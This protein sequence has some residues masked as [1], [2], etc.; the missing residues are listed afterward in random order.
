LRLEVGK[1]CSRVTY[2][3][4]ST[5]RY[6]YAF[7]RIS[8]AFFDMHKSKYGDYRVSPN[9][10][11]RIVVDY[12]HLLNQKILTVSGYEYDLY[13]ETRLTVFPSSIPIS[14]NVPV[15]E[16]DSE[17]SSDFRDSVC[18]P[19]IEVD[20][21]VE[22]DNC[23]FSSDA[24]REIISF[25]EN[26]SYKESDDIL[27]DNSD[28]EAEGFDD[29]KNM[30]SSECYSE[31]TDSITLSFPGFDSSYFDTFFDDD[32]VDI[33]PQRD[34][35]DKNRII[36]DDECVDKEIKQDFVFDNRSC[37]QDSLVESRSLGEIFGTSIGDFI[38]IGGSSGGSEFG[39]NS[40]KR[41]DRRRK[42]KRIRESK[43]KKNDLNKGSI[44]DTTNSVY[45]W[46]DSV[47]DIILKQNDID[48]TDDLDQDIS[49]SSDSSAAIY[50][51]KGRVK[52]ETIDWLQQFDIDDV[53]VDGSAYV[54]NWSYSS[55]PLNV[56]N[57]N[58]KNNVL[59]S[60]YSLLDDFKSICVDSLELRL[61]VDNFTKD[62]LGVMIWF[63]SDLIPMNSLSM[64]DIHD[65]GLDNEITLYDV[66]SYSHYIKKSYIVRG[67]DVFKSFD[68]DHCWTLD[69]GPPPPYYINIA[70]YGFKER[71]IEVAGVDSKLKFHLILS[72]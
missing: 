34:N 27:S 35:V 28:L 1:I 64:N 46:N 50:R 16:Y 45:A 43:K 19:V 22:C 55:D 11:K 17:S 18:E 38:L 29:L 72:E 57:N 61:R 13:A 36:L 30:F 70:L 6:E 60:F 10:L 67:D 33:V 8:P 69:R 42:N 44:E 63:S 52:F 25:F 53:A 68:I 31:S 37:V 14:I 24:I 71:T 62:V 3:E 49:N 39:S 40:K 4:L 65:I 15:C 66:Q 12:L 59:S 54:L 21:S 48:N 7:T 9:F 58:M 2:E 32:E 56:A 41:R 5:D 26:S 51:N 47:E 20:N 23:S